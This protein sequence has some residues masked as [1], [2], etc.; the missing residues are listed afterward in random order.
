MEKKLFKFLEKNN[1]KAVANLF[2]KNTLKNNLKIIKI[3]SDSDL[4]EVA[5]KLK[6]DYLAMILL[7][8]PV[9]KKQIVLDSLNDKEL[10]KIFNDLSA[11]QTMEDR[12][13]VV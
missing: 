9:E 2:Y 10:D 11:K 13:S 5:S 6:K 12:K 3:L 8:L 7:H 1:Y 4:V